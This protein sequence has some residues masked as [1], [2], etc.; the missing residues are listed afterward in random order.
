MEQKRGEEYL[1]KDISVWDMGD[2]QQA[3]GLNKVYDNYQQ[4]R[5]MLTGKQP[6]QLGPVLASE[7]QIMVRMMFQVWL[8][9]WK[10]IDDEDKRRRQLAGKPFRKRHRNA[11][12]S[13]YCFLAAAHLRGHPE[14]AEEVRT[15][16]APDNVAE[17]ERI[18]A[19]V[20]ATFGWEFVPLPLHE[21]AVSKGGSRGGGGG[22]RGK[23]KAAQ[24]AETVAT[25]QVPSSSADAATTN[26]SCNT[27]ARSSAVES[28]LQNGGK[29]IT[30]ESSV[31][32]V[33][34]CAP[35]A[36]RTKSKNQNN[37]K[38][39]RPLETTVN[40]SNSSDPKRLRANK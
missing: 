38:K 31:T 7:I 6:R 33:T 23:K 25:D 3:T 29:M 13:S 27:D 12:N 18:R 28:E 37:N 2:A 14:M 35:K 1:V 30:E 5:M 32:T 24:A 16:W 26:P 8:E 39:K 11:P 15:V 10:M 4:L 9:F 21:R 19:L 34:P 40:S 20:F 22:S 17:K 36:N